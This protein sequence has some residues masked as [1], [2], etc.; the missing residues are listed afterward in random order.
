VCGEPSSTKI[1]PSIPIKLYMD[2]NIEAL[3]EVL[4]SAED[5]NYGVNDAM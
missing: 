3:G 1:E 5:M 4:P 2:S